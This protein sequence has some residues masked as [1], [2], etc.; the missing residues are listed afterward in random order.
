MTLLQR[1]AGGVGPEEA[2]RR[3][4]VV[5]F[6]VCPP[7]A[8]IWTRTHWPKR[9]PAC[10]SAG[11]RWRF[12]N[13]AGDGQ[14]VERA[15]P[16]RHWRRGTAIST[17][18]RTPAGTTASPSRKWI[19]RGS[20]SC[21][22]PRETMPAGLGRR[23]APTMVSCSARPMSLRA[24]STPSCDS[25]TRIGGIRRGA[26]DQSRSVVEG[27]FALVRGFPAGNAFT[28]A[29]KI[30]DHLMAHGEAGLRR[31]PPL[32]YSGVRLPAALVESAAAVL[33]QHE[34]MPRRGYL[35]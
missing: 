10:W 12:T 20:F 15:K 34:L 33:Q 30:L 21:A 11:F 24:N 16:F 35:E 26:R 13:S 32:L 2:L 29:N 17:C 7:R 22:A 5:G 18:S 31:Q 1:R 14:R 23:A 28:N 19:S 3:A 6:T 8:V 4:N 9:F 25:S 27:C